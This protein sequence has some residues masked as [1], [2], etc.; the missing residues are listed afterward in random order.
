MNDRLI[1]ID[2]EKG[3]VATGTAHLSN[4]NKKRI[5]LP[6]S[7]ILYMTDNQDDTLVIWL[8]NAGDNGWILI[9][10]PQEAERVRSRY[11][12]SFC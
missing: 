8:K 9:N 6:A 11:M 10:D 5:T 12:H 2:A 7:N 3:R 1:Y 4:I